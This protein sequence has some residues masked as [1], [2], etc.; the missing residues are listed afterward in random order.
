RFSNRFEMSS[1][2]DA[3]YHILHVW[4][5]IGMDAQSD[6]L[7]LCFATQQQL[8]EATA[9]PTADAPNTLPIVEL[10]RR[11]ASKTYTINPPAEFNR[12][13]VTQVKGITFDLMV[14]LRNS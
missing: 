12:A 5:T 3:V 8:N 9:A 1:V 4:K 11:Y 13:P 6:E 7:Y 2:N 14:Q 10:L